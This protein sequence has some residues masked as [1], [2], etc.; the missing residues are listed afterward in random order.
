M[1]DRAIARIARLML[2][3]AAL[4]ICTS[5]VAEQKKA[6]NDA[7]SL[8]GDWEYAI[9]GPVKMVLH[10]EVG[11]DGALAGSI[12][13][14]DSPPQHI[15]L[16]DIQLSGKI[17]KYIWPQRGTIMEVVQA[18]GNSMLGAQ[19]WHRVNTSAL[20]ARDVAGDWESKTTSGTYSK[21]THILHLRLD[22]GG[23]LTGYLDELLAIPRRVP[24]REVRLQ[25]TTLT[26]TLDNGN[27]LHGT[28][29]ND[30]RTILGAQAG[31]TWQRARTLAQALAED[32]K[33]RP[34]PTDGTWSGIITPVLWSQVVKTPP[35]GDFHYSVHLGSAPV[36]CSVRLEIPTGEQD[37]SPLDVP[38]E[39]KREGANVQIFGPYAG[40]FIGTLSG[41][42]LTGSWTTGKNNP[43]FVM[44]LSSEPM[45]VRLTRSASAA[46]T[47]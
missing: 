44:A 4:G 23:S 36:T 17:L 41:D 12:D 31:L 27:V 38:C 7:A 39:M 8:A 6:G 29:S 11:A 9:N 28:F 16:K 10:L 21:V 33:E 34:L 20:S 46:A 3:S 45:K 30:R 19:I 42:Q 13:T 5:A 32:S 25:G 14:P 24:L 35:K 37:K 18:D 43:V 22:S 2:I 47:H 40:A 26:Y 15:V 1:N